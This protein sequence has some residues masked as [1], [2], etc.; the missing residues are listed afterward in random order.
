MKSELSLDFLTYEMSKVTLITYNYYG[1]KNE[2]YIEHFA[3]CLA[4]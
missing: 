2:T 4:Q 1:D 3:Q